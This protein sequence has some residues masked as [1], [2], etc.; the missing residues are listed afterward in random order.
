MI[1]CGLATHYLQSAV[2]SVGPFF[3]F[4][5]HTLSWASQ[6]CYLSLHSNLFSSNRGFHYSRNN[7][8]NWLLMILQSLKLLSVH[9]VMSFILIARVYLTGICFLYFS[10]W[11]WLSFFFPYFF[12]PCLHNDLSVD[13]Q[14]HLLSLAR[15]SN[16]SI[17][18]GGC[19]TTDYV[20]YGCC[21][22]K[23]DIF[24][25]LWRTILQL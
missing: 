24:K 18:M 14:F 11:P 4:L 16:N 22:R 5:S 8:E 3:F 9:T 13:I 23:N 12:L 21:V 17:I 25:E 19:I 6:Q 20:S 10:L 1:G 2:S 7:L 15:S